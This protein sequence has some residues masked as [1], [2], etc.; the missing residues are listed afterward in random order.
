VVPERGLRQNRQCYFANLLF[1]PVPRTFFVGVRIDW[2]VLR[3]PIE[4]D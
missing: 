3:L 1:Y 4:T 2:K